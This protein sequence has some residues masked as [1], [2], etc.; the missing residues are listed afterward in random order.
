MH[1]VALNTSIYEKVHTVL[2][3]SSSHL[4]HE[5]WDHSV[6]YTAFVVKRFLADSGSAFL[7]Y[8]SHAVRGVINGI[9]CKSS[10]EKKC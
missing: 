3:R 8:Q 5:I 6:E 4:E 7:T 2:V 10:F 9:G 1:L